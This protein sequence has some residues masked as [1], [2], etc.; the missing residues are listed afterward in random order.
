MAGIRLASRTAV[1]WV[2]PGDGRGEEERRLRIYSRPTHKKGGGKLLCNIGQW[3]SCRG[4]SERNLAN[5]VLE[6]LQGLVWSRFGD[7]VA[8][9]TDSNKCKVM[10]CVIDG[11][12]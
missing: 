12:I 9:T 7:F 6:K 3:G 11:S 5:Q 10:R 4:S 8:T 2:L 1:V